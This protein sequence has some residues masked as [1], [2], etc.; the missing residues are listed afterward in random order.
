[1]EKT[2]KEKNSTSNWFDLFQNQT[3]H[4]NRILD[5]AKRIKTAIQE[6]YKNNEESFADDLSDFW[7][8]DIDAQIDRAAEQNQPNGLKLFTRQYTPIIRVYKSDDVMEN[9]SS[10]LPCQPTYNGMVLD[11]SPLKLNRSVKFIHKHTNAMF[12]GNSISQECFFD[13]AKQFF[14]LD[15]LYKHIKYLSRLLTRFYKMNNGKTIVIHVNC[16]LRG[17]NSEVINERGTMTSGFRYAINYI[18]TIWGNISKQADFI[19]IGSY[20]G[21]LNENELIAQ[22]NDVDPN[23]VTEI[24]SDYFQN[25]FLL[26][27]NMEFIND[28]PYTS[29]WSDLIFPPKFTNKLNPNESPLN[30]FFFQKYKPDGKFY[31]TELYLPKHLLKNRDILNKTIRLSSALLKEKN[32]EH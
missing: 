28:P 3:D 7:V 16:K 4:S 2:E 31:K 24:I 30:L 23:I 8:V 14:L 17:C 12:V 9:R 27:N 5:T 19:I 1:M 10:L 29:D 15:F 18:N 25:D 13:V 32:R 20:D 22:L 26:L 6:Y 11:G 21:Y